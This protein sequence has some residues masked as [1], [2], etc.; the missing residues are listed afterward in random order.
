M[1][2]ENR[3]QKCKTVTQKGK[4]KF[5]LISYFY[6]MFL[7]FII[8]ILRFCVIHFF[9]SKS[10]LFENYSYVEWVWKDEKIKKTILDETERRRI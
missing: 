3:T 4:R 10:I 8:I 5:D 9:V 7:R 6:W 2:T 1:K